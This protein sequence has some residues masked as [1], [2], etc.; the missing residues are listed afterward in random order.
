MLWYAL[1]RNLWMCRSII[2]I[3]YLTGHFSLPHLAE[4]S[5]PWYVQCRSHMFVLSILGGNGHWKNFFQ[6]YLVFC[7]GLGS[8]GPLSGH[9]YVSKK[10]R[11]KSSENQLFTLW[12]AVD[13]LQRG[14]P[15]TWRPWTRTLVQDP[16]CVE[17]WLNPTEEIDVFNCRF[18]I[19]VHDFRSNQKL[20]M[21]ISRQDLV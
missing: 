14:S 21:P 9:I 10:K 1:S 12:T 6:L 17:S 8:E 5:S 3:L 15:I 11:K 18:S 20:A 7:S 16:A 2:A 19:T 13:H 4:V